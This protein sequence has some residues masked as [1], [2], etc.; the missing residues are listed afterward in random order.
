MPPRARATGTSDS[1]DTG[2][3]TLRLKHGIHTV[4]LFVTPDQTFADITAD[5]LEL[6][7][8]RYPDGLTT[9]VAPPKTTPIPASDDGSRVIYGVL[10]APA[11][12]AQGWKNLRAEESDTV[13]GK[14][15]KDMAPVAFAFAGEDEALRDVVFEVEV[16]VLEEEEEE[17]EEY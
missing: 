4:F 1:S 3:L 14:R 11:D 6:L 16:P 13:A 7:R 9:S 17:E 10:K 15:L 5:L 2:V 12:W 8:E